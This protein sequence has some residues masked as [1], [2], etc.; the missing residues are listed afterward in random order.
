MQ[1]GASV[2]VVFGKVIRQLREENAMTQEKLAELADIDRTYIYRLET[3][4]RSPSLD[5]VFR[6]ADALKISPGQLLDKV[7]KQR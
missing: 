2:K 6:L 5:I 4:K 3:G 1:K 7:N